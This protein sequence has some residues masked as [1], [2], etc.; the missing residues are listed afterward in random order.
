MR[1]ST[2]CELDVALIHG[3]MAVVASQSG[4][5]LAFVS[6]GQGVTDTLPTDSCPYERFGAITEG[7]PWATPASRYIEN[8]LMPFPI[9]PD[10]HGGM[11]Y[12]GQKKQLRDSQVDC[13]P[14]FQQAPQN[15][16]CAPYACVPE[17]DRL[18]K[19]MWM[20]GTLNRSRPPDSSPYTITFKAMDHVQVYNAGKLQPVMTDIDGTTTWVLQSYFTRSAYGQGKESSV[21]GGSTAPGEDRAICEYIEG[22]CRGYKATLTCGLLQDTVY[23]GTGCAIGDGSDVLQDSTGGVWCKTNTTAVVVP[24]TGGTIVPIIE[25]L[26]YA[27]SLVLIISGMNGFLS[28]LCYCENVRR[29]WTAEPVVS[30][31]P[32]DAWEPQKAHGAQPQSRGDE[33]SNDIMIEL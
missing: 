5:N 8:N 31:F 19:C 2:S 16:I 29:A 13:Q 1:G 18:C 20:A 7:R 24:L 15:R 22:C 26:L 23:C 28:Y 11:A 30:R 6:T 21:P 32:A 27:F 4:S 33:Q 9:P 17:L 25:W 3:G 12:N 10:M 14:G